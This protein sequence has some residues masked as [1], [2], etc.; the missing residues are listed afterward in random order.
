M[1]F[2]TKERLRLA[3]LASGFDA[4]RFANAEVL[5]EEMHRFTE[6]IDRGYQGDMAYMAR[7]VDKRL[8]VRTIVPGAASVIVVAVSYFTNHEHTQDHSV[9]KISRYAWGSDYHDIIS[10][11][12]DEAI[13]VLKSEHPEHAFR[14]YTDTGPVLE[15]AWAVRSG[16]GWQGKNSNI[17][18]RDLGSYFFLGVIIT[19]LAIPPDSP[20]TDHCGT[21]TAC[22]DACPTHAIVQPAVVDAR[23]CLSYWTIET[24]GEGEMP[25]EIRE[26]LDG[27][28]YGCDVCQEVCPWN[29]FALPT[30]IP[31]FQPRL[32]ETSLALDRV[33]TMSDEE[34]RERF[35]GSAIKR[36]KLKGLQRNARE[37][38]SYYRNALNGNPESP[39]AEVV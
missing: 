1:D 34:F 14:R 2:P 35:K 28:L 25:P 4:V 9:G 19:T 20:V 31:E 36:T 16:L 17:L 18:S 12:L 23:R 8:D 39:S 26:H 6:W 13:D 29:R 32:G 37:L 21:C 5:H 10:T 11:K 15:K 3:F 27:W 7:N 33:S 30:P 24:K 22:L 38:S